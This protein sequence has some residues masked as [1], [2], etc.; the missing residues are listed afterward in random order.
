V[1][2]I[3]AATLRRNWQLIGAVAVFAIF[4]A[5]HLAFFK[6]AAARYRAALEATGGLDAFEA[7][8]AR[9]LLPPRVFALLS[10][11]MLTPQDAQDR[12]SSGALGVI[13]LEDLG[14]VASRAGLDVLAS[15]PGAVTQEPHTTQVRAHLRL[16]GSYAEIT[17]FFDELSRASGLTLVERFRIVAWPEGG[18]VLEIWLARLHFKQATN[19]P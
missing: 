2:P 8:A 17:S 13:L 1:N 14:R 6:P 5:I 9:P 18:D 3:L 11:N 7:A 15:E 12:G 19:T 10:R 16:R 4:T